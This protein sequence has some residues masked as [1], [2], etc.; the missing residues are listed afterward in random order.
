MEKIDKDCKCLKNNIN[1]V[2]CA[3]YV[4]PSIFRAYS[5][6]HRKPCTRIQAYSYFFHFSFPAT[7]LIPY[8]LTLI[9]CGIPL[10]YLELALGQYLSLG[11]IKAW[12]V[13]CPALKGLC[14]I[15]YPE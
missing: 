11:T 6:L 14:F 13:V 4:A 9:T 15:R 8:F 5:A 7:F 2:F 1:L 12:A 3:S 10:F